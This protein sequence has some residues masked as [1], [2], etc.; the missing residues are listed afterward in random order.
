MR[1][2]LHVCACSCTSE[3]PTNNAGSSLGL[4]VQVTCA[5]SLQSPIPRCPACIRPNCRGL[6][7]CAPHAP[8]LFCMHHA[9]CSPRPLPSSS[10]RLPLSFSRCLGSCK[11]LSSMRE[12]VHRIVS[13]S[14][15]TKRSTERANIACL[16][17]LGK[18]FTKTLYIS[19]LYLDKVRQAWARRCHLCVCTRAVGRHEARWPPRQDW[20]RWAGSK[21]G[22]GP[23]DVLREC[24]RG[25]TSVREGLQGSGRER[26]GPAPSPVITDTHLTHSR[27]SRCTALA[28]RALVK[29]ARTR[30]ID[31]EA[32]GKK[33]RW[34]IACLVLAVALR[35][36]VEVYRLKRMTSHSKGWGL[37]D[38][39]PI[40][41]A[42][43]GE[44]PP[45]GEKA[46]PSAAQK[47]QGPR[48]GCQQ[49]MCPAMGS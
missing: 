44:G 43:Q 14:N 40:R 23:R 5:P 27:L 3:L 38:N 17:L 49:R 7:H 45:R 33:L 13:S 18:L 48:A 9:V 34:A 41:Y 8:V 35:T 28:V 24:S 36:Y 12:A 42:P 29:M 37:E 31:T 6:R 4:S 26:T 10:I 1:T 21:G 30:S 15:C 32:L 39:L 16:S 2:L 20:V 47:A 11:C 25:Y 19:V 22:L 46:G